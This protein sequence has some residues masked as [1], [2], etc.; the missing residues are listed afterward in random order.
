MSALNETI[1]RLGEIET[2]DKTKILHALRGLTHKSEF[3]TL[4]SEP[5]KWN[6]KD[7]QGREWHWLLRRFRNSSEFKRFFLGLENE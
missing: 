2:F 1:D 7:S 3:V 5:G 6:Y 4:D